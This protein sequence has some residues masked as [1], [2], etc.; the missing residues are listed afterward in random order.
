MNPHVEK[1][2]K[3]PLYKRMLVV[4]GVMAAIAV[5]FYFAMF[6]PKMKEYN[7][8]VK[9]SSDLQAEITQKKTIA[10]NLVK[11]QQE[12][13]EMEKK[14]ED[15]KK[16]LPSSKEI[17]D[18][19]QAIAG[20]AGS[21]N[22]DIKKFQP[23]DEVPKDFYAEVPVTL[24]LIGAYHDIGKFFYDVGEMSRI[25]NIGNIKVKL[26]QGAKDAKKV[27]VAVDCQAV[28]YRYM[29]PEEKAQTQKSKP[30]AK[31]K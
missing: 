17:P 12:L 28:T 11:L 3:I 4:I 6:L 8:L 29:S 16:E 24:S 23:G 18:L 10:D 9:K 30:G 13:K 7:A 19:L 20:I 31:K 26:A 14:L 25:V 2:I 27:H 5:A 21:N 1:F 15:S 22:L